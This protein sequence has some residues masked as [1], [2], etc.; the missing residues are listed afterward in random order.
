MPRIIVLD[1]NTACRIAAGEVVERPVSVVK[2]LVENSL[3][4]DAGNITVA[5]A[6]GG[7]ESIT[8][9]D[10]GYG[11]SQED[12]PLAFQRHATS[13]IKTAGDL[14]QIGTLGF[15]G[16]ALPSIAAVSDLLIKTRIRENNE[17]YCLNIRGGKLIEEGP[18]GC[19]IGTMV[20]VRELFFN[21]PARLKHL[22][23]KATEIG[24]V[25]E[26]LYKM[27]LINP[28]VG[29][30]LTH[31]GRQ[32]FQSPGSAKLLETV[33]AVYGVNVASVMIPLEYEDNEIKIEGY[34]GKP[35]LSRSSK[36][37]IT[38]AVNGRIVRN[39]AIHA[40]IEEGYRG[41]LTVGRY[42]VA[43][44][45]LKM[46]PGMLDVNVHPAK[47]EIKI[48]TE[49]KVLSI[50]TSTVRKALGEVNLIP[51][52]SRVVPGKVSLP[53]SEEPYHL[54]LSP[55]IKAKPETKPISHLIASS[56]SGNL[57]KAEEL[58]NR[59][60]YKQDSIKVVEKPVQP[61]QQDN[62]EQQV[63]EAVL[64]Y[65]S[66][67]FPELR[68]VGQVINM[69]II[70]GS[71][72]TLYIIDQH[73]AHERVLFEKYFSNLQEGNAEVQYLLAPVNINLKYYEL[74]LLSQ[75]SRTL[76]ALGFVLEEFGRDAVL[77][78]GIPADCSAAEAQQIIM[79][80]IDVLVETGKLGTAELNYKIA[81]LLAC[82]AAIKGGDSLSI[83]SM[84]VLIDLLA[85]SKEPYTCPHGRPTVVSFSRQELDTMFKRT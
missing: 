11:I 19:R 64:N 46:P 6:G 84:Q 20:T 34:I 54:D 81:S 73:A 30:L 62:G 21:T 24:L 4:A 37:Q 78:R 29:F 3:D 45:L 23:S 69:Y 35:E 32:V 66:S 63:A 56:G 16:E 50:I 1:E 61:A 40:A 10:N 22:K 36:Q 53:P 47:M 80:M 14:Y 68:V 72:A 33:A 7:L 57:S 49:E 75:H 39:L 79:D 67:N 55:V 71:D 51:G 5:I 31:N 59:S 43:V 17:G 76:K 25:N 82:K 2:E 15:R 26:L 8:V 9:V 48:E 18:V 65:Q 44:L 42:P 83:Q 27:A 74:E 60:D 12:A 77:L 41:L 28:G 70:A 13:K 85:K 38:T 52:F 58:K